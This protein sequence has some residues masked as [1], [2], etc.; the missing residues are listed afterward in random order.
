VAAGRVLCPNCGFEFPAAPRRSPTESRDK[1]QQYSTDP[2]E[3][4][5]FRYDK[6]VSKARG[7]GF[8]PGWAA[9]QY[10]KTYGDWPPYEWGEATKA[11]AASDPYWQARIAAREAGREAK[12][13]GAGRAQ[14][15]EPAPAEPLSEESGT[16]YED[17]TGSF[18]EWLRGEGVI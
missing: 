13:R 4:R 5:R 10:K 17:E 11:S 2:S 1:L 6:F 7:A 18:N 15:Q 3:M 12:E 14:V 9:F 8:K 16:S